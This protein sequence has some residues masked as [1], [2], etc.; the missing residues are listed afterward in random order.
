MKIEI[1]VKY[2]YRCKMLAAFLVN[3]EECPTLHG[4]ASHSG[5]IVTVTYCVPPYRENEP[6]FTIRAADGWRSTVLRHELEPIG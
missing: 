6:L 3:K 5:Q 2:I 4:L 1:G